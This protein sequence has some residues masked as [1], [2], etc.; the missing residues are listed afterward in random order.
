MSAPRRVAAEVGVSGGRRL[1]EG[2]THGKR[3]LRRPPPSGRGFTVVE[4]PSP[5]TTIDALTD[6]ALPSDLVDKIPGESGGTSLTRL[7][8]AA[9]AFRAATSLELSRQELAFH[10]ESPGF[11]GVS[12]AARRAGLDPGQP[13]AGV[14]WPNATSRGPGRV[15]RSM[16][17]VTGGAGVEAAVGIQAETGR[18]SHLTSLSGV[19]RVRTHD[20]FETRAAQFP[21]IKL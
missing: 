19:S 10:L 6:L 20:G 3:Q 21:V 11:E 12:C 2:S 17:G 9:P 18:P 14:C 15:A 4:Q 13:P 5:V 8:V 16:I 1:N 7:G